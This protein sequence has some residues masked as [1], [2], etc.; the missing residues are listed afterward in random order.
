M[1]N[2]PR[3]SSMLQHAVIPHLRIFYHVDIEHDEEDINM[4]AGIISGWVLSASF[5]FKVDR[6]IYCGTMMA[7]PKQLIVT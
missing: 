1:R 4:Y 3:I 6:D 7:M 5:N 2:I